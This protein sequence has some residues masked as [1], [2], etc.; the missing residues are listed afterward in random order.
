MAEIDCSN[1]NGKFGTLI[2]NN[3]ILS[4]HFSPLYKLNIFPCSYCSFSF[5]PL[6]LPLPST[7]I[8]PAKY[9][10]G[11]TVY[12][13]DHRN[14][15]WI[16]GSRHS[17]LAA[18]SRNDRTT[19]TG[20]NRWKQSYN[21]FVPVTLMRTA[22]TSIH[23]RPKKAIDT[24]IRPQLRNYLFLHFE[25]TT[26]RYSNILSFHLSALDFFLSQNHGFFI[27]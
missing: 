20:S 13:L 8:Q 5:S 2:Q 1:F 17:N 21:Q 26:T 11:C 27:F 18:G 25:N 7:K 22:T 12:E 4:L 16:G 9:H 24:S 19:F 3:N 14:Q 15:I 23:C 10:L 6:Y